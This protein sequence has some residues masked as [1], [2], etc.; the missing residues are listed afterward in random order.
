[1]EESSTPESAPEAG[2]SV[3][4]A[5]PPDA[6]PRTS[7]D[8]GAGEPPPAP[9][10]KE[11]AAESPPSSPT[12]R[13]AWIL[14]VAT[15]V[16]CV[17]SFFGVLIAPGIPGN[18]TG[19]IVEACQDVSDVFAYAT[20]GLLMALVFMG[21]YELARAP[22]IALAPRV[23]AVGAAGLVV[24]LAAPAMRDKLH[25]VAAIFLAI[26][27]AIVA[28]TTAWQGAR[29]AHTRAV[30]VVIIA[31]ALA[32]VARVG[33]WELA[34]DAGE[35][36]STRLYDVA[37]AIATA[38]VVLEGLG[39]LA[40]AAWLGTRGGV[41]GR[42][43]S[44][45]AIAGAFLV[46]WGAAR[47]VHP[48]AATWQ[49]VLH[50]ALADAPGTPPPLGLSAVAT[51]LACCAIFLGVVAISLRGQMVAVL[52][53]LALTLLSRGTFDVPLRA[54]AIVAAGQWLL[55][56]TVD[57]RSMWRALVATRVSAPRPQ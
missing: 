24:A 29:T 49:A 23:L 47:G 15:I 28:I 30:S 5:A 40:A 38:G 22:R 17:A 42:I 19:R 55:L 16:A 33:A 52:A 18:A 26:A 48:G 54:L 50:T 25:P 11:S 9:A 56:A 12:L 37:A 46:T 57:D 44:N 14:R 53:A 20:A 13:A 1:M 2:A 35:R 39:Q 51:F 45:L 32:S 4:D 10:A 43:L 27:S 36:G 6:A 21:S 41:A 7:G 8:D 31:M 34:G 3:P